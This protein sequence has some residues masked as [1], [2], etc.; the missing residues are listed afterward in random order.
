MQQHLKTCRSRYG[1]AIGYLLPEQYVT[2]VIMNRILIVNRMYSKIRILKMGIE[3]K[4]RIS[5]ICNSEFS[6]KK[7]L[8][9]GKCVLTPLSNVDSETVLAKVDHKY[10]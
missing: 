1:T 9:V 8:L 6:R 2:R 10:K 4:I 3:I 7:I 5:E